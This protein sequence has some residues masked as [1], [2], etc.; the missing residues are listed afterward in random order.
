MGWDSWL[1][2]H[3][4]R[5]RTAFKMAITWGV[6]PSRTSKAVPSGAEVK[7]GLQNMFPR[8]VPNVLGILNFGV[9]VS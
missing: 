2:R 5:N 9:A 3:F 4:I 6:S 1:R 8:I 7:Q